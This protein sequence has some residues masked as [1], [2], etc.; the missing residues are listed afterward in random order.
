MCA[1]EG[2]NGGKGQIVKLQKQAGAL[3]AYLGVEFDVQ[4]IP[5]PT[6]PLRLTLPKS[7]CL[8]SLS[9]SH[10]SVNLRTLPKKVHSSNRAK[11]GTSRCFVRIIFGR[12]SLEFKSSLAHRKNRR[13]CV[14]SKIRLRKCYICNLKITLIFF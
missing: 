7:P 8:C 14:M 2:S 11:L 12:G 10:G 5:G 4:I 1:P 13:V 3:F 9:G 6:V